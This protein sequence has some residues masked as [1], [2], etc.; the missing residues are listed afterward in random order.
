MLLIGKQPNRLIQ[1]LL[2]IE[3]LK[4]KQQFALNV[5]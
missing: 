5:S 3:L 2:S 4:I 1:R